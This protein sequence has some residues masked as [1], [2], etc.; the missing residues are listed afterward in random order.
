MYFKPIYIF[1]LLSIFTC[2]SGFSQ[3]SSYASSLRGLDS[4]SLISQLHNKSKSNFISDF[5]SPG[6]SLQQYLKKR[7]QPGS[8]LRTEKICFDTAERFFIKNDTITYYPRTPVH[9]RDGNFLLVGEYATYSVA[10]GLHSGGSLMKVDEKGTILWSKLYDS[11][12]VQTPWYL[13]Y[14]KVIELADGSIIMAGGVNNTIANNDD[15][16]VTK[17][18]SNGQIIWSKTFTSRFWV[19]GH[20]SAD[21][22]RLQ[23]MKQDPFTG[24]IYLCGTYWTTGKGILKLNSIDGSIIWSKSYQLSQSAAFDEAFG[25]D[26]RSNDIVYFG[27]SLGIKNL[28][29]V[30]V[31]DKNTGVPIQTK[32]FQS[33]PSVTVN[34]DILKPEELSVLNNGH[35]IISGSCYGQFIYNWNGIDTFYQASVIEYDNSLNFVKA[36]TFRNA[37]QNNMGNTKVTV[38]PDGSGMFSMLE[39]FSGYTANV[40]YIQFNNGIIVKQRKRFYNGEGMPWENNA[41]K[42][43]DGGDLM[44]KLLGDSATN[45]NKIEFLKLHTS[46][47]SSAC[48]GYNDSRTFVEPF[49]VETVPASLDSVRDKA[50][51]ESINQ[52]ITVIDNQLEKTPACFQVSY[53]DTLKIIPSDTVLCFRQPLTITIHKNKACGTIVPLSFDTTATNVTQLND[54]TFLF[55]FRKPWTGYIS[56]SLQGCTLMKD[57][58]LIKVLQAPG[59]VSLGPDSSICPFNTI[60]LNAHSGYASYKWQDGKTDSTY[61]ATS[62]GKYYVTVNDACGEIYSDTINIT[63][64]PPVPLSIG[65]DRTKCNNDTLRLSAPSGF[66][67]YSWSPVYNINSTTAQDVIINPAKDTTY[68][69][70]AEKTPGCFGFDTIRIKVNTSPIINLGKDTSFCSGD[71]IIL[72]A[73]TGFSNYTWN[74]NNGTQQLVAKQKGDYIIKATTAQDC[75]SADTLSVLNVFENPVVQLNQDT[76]IC[77]GSSKTLDAGIFAFYLWNTGSISKTIT[78]NSIGIYAVS[79]TDNNG[80]KGADTYYLKTILP[81]PQQFLPGDTTICSYGDITLQTLQ[82]YNAYLWSNNSKAPVLKITKP[83]TYWLQ[84]TDKYNCTGKDSIEVLLKDCMLGFYIPNTFT[85]NSDQRND[86]FRPLLFGNI[87]QYKFTVYNRWG[88]MIY[89]STTPGEG[90]DGFVKGME[91]KTGIYMWTCMY[92]LEGETPINKKGTVTLIK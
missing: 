91:E 13:Y 86:I 61:N 82:N 35:Y 58:V 89:Q 55:L 43:K 40:Y 69:I 2:I 1:F 4:L 27:R 47:T 51:R 28:T 48:I 87:I 60:L 70:K 8:L 32:F 78:V 85:P 63:A 41:V 73:G 14:Y 26:I 17:T 9:T 3:R 31:I 42:A 12:G 81:L 33:V 18:N 64:A 67:N 72:N 29:S 34:Q 74:G 57:S 46:D 56:G 37:I 36:Y 25:M 52:T 21:F 20:G 22:Y 53:C 68:Y 16:I 62:P 45:I 75:S 92:Q 79:V 30:F 49:D 90:W 84:V 23:Q 80:C 76:A 65:P 10:N 24:D 11:V 38:Y 88:Q 83:G 66:L 71:S 44:V 50:F 77:T 7:V 59:P 54:T 19:S 5:S 15:F 39:F 6:H